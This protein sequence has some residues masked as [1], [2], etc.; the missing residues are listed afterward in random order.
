MTYLDSQD[1]S[2]DHLSEKNILFNVILF[3]AQIVRSCH[4]V[5]IDREGRPGG[6]GLKV[7]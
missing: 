5:C 3:I 2:Q 7:C 4:V 1:L 6:K